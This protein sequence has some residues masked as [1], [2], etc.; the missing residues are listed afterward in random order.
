MADFVS[1]PACHGRGLIPL[2]DAEPVIAHTDATAQAAQEQRRER[3]AAVL[4]NRLATLK[5]SA[6]DRMAALESLV[7]GSGTG[8]RL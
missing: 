6:E 4:G 5:T 2:E 7:Y 1:C 3:E 8:E